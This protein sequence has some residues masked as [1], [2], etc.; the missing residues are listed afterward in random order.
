MSEE[1]R[2]E[3]EIRTRRK[4]NTPW[5]R[6]ESLLWGLQVFPGPVR[7]RRCCFLSCRPHDGTQTWFVERCCNSV[8]FCSVR[9]QIW[10]SVLQAISLSGKGDGAF[11]DSEKPR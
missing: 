11:V 4:Q 6:G 10:P 7:W 3:I 2:T 1:M 5:G 8:G 9:T